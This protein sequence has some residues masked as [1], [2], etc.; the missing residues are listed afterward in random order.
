MKVGLLLVVGSVVAVLASLATAGFV[1]VR[2][3]YG[4]YGMKI[5]DGR[6]VEYDG[7]DLVLRGINH[8]YAWHRARTETFADVKATGANAI[9]VVMSIGRLWPANTVADVTEV[10]RL[11][12]RHRLICVIDAHDT[13]GYGQVPGAA[14]I[15]HA[16]DFWI[17]VRAALVGQENHVIL[18]VANEP[19]GNFGFAG[20]AAETSDAIRR[21]RSAGFQ[22]MLM[23]DAPDWGQDASFTMRDR[24]AEVL[25]AD[26]AR[27][28]V[29]SVHMYGTFDT[30]AKVD[31]YLTSFTSREWPIVVGE[32][33]DRHLYGEPDE[34][35]IMRYTQR[36]G[37]GYLGWSWSGNTDPYAYLDAVLDF[38]PTRR[39]PW[40]ERLV[41]GPDGIA[42]TS[43]EAAI[44]RR[45]ALRG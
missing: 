28:T 5:V 40:G 35:S 27:K 23:V 36:Y 24:A 18:N 16:V 42:T 17:G 44:Y 29:L 26:P 2:P 37:I 14:T 1:V 45:P 12:R 11:C 30:A 13:I 7:S 4:D 38:D 25:A 19:Y 33:A 32:F 39:T 22:N 21:L 15:A 31:D 10:V 6:L 34:D 41:A 43:T 8:G 20:W 3:L 9:R